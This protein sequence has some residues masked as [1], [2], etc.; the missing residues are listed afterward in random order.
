M[1]SFTTFRRLD[2]QCTPVRRL[3]P[4]KL[5]TAKGEFANMEKLG[6]VRA[7][8][9]PGPPLHMVPKSDSGCRPCGD[10]RRLNDATIPDRYP[11]SHAQDFS[12]RLAGK[13]VFSKVDLIRGYHQVPVNAEDIP[14]T[15]VIT[16][17]GLFEFLRMPFG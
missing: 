12:A 7:L 8:T 1:E 2:L 17:F 11:V 3:N 9:A 10:Y 15:A 14:K 16:P 5:A 6:I 13:T 4:A